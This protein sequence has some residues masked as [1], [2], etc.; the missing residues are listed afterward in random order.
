MMALQRRR[1]L[2]SVLVAWG[3]LTGCGQGSVG[4]EEE[5]LL[6]SLLSAITASGTPDL[7]VASV[8]GPAGR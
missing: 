7:W 8:T 1:W 2:A 5:S 6:D 3:A 4:T